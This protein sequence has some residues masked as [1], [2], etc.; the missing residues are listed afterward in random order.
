VGILAFGAVGLL[1]LAL[2]LLDRRAAR[3]RRSPLVSAA[4][5]V[6]LAFALA[7]T[8]LAYVKPY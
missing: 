5:A 7:M 1:L 2:P 3:G 4:G 6:L 8:V